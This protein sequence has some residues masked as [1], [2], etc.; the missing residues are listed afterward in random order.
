M[1][2]CLSGANLQTK[3]NI[4]TDMRG[5]ALFDHADL[6]IHDWI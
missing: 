1:N 3:D 6:C 5:I 2:V 4:S